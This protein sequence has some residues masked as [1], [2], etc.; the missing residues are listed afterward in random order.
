MSTHLELV[1]AKQKMDLAS[2][3]AFF[4]AVFGTIVEYYDYALYGFCAS[5][6]ASQFFPTDD[7]TVALLKT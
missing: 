2:L 3:K 6:L 7:P 4:P 1:N 5:L